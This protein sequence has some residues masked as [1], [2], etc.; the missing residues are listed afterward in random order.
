VRFTTRQRK[1]FVAVSVVATL[2]LAWLLWPGRQMARVKELQKTLFSEEAKALSPDERREK[3]RELREVTEKLS[4]QQRTELR[5]EANKRQQTEMERYFKMTPAEKKKYLDQQIDRMEAMRRQMQANG[6]APPR[7]PGGP[8]GPPSNRPPQTPEQREQR[9][10]DRLDMST[11][12]LRAERD[13]FR[14]EMEQRRK[15]RGLP[16]TPPF[17]PRR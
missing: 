6:G 3:F 9:R 10:K 14:K 12:E 8:G 4:P 2:V 17:P 16:P 11:P 1:G 13:Q 15:E 7:G 5:A